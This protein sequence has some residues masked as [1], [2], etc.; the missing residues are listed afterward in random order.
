VK[1][2]AR[3]LAL[4]LF[5]LAAPVMAQETA[6]KK[7]QWDLDVK[8]FEGIGFGFQLSERFSVRPLFGGI[9]PAETGTEFTLGADLRYE[10]T[11]RSAFAPYLFGSLGYGHNYMVET[12]TGASEPVPHSGLFG[13]G[14]GVRQPVSK[15]WALFGEV[16]LQHATAPGHGNGVWN[17]KLSD[18]DSVRFGFGVT[19]NLKK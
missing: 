16:S 7:G 3:F 18:R 17:L 1:I 19:L 5:V 11:E 14:V 10:L 6:P 4:G 13:V 9:R 15:R 8:P 2:P 12:D